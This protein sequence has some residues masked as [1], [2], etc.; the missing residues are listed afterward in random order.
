MVGVIDRD[1][2]MHA[3]VEEREL[4][5][6]ATRETEPSEALEVGAGAAARPPRAAQPLA[7]RSMWSRC[8][9]GVP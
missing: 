6:I 9:R 2:R 4:M 3:M 1:G 7:C 8:E 5:A